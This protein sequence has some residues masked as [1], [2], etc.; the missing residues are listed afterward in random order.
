MAAEYDRSLR[1][2]QSLT[3]AS[4]SQMKQYDAGLKALAIDSGVAPTKLSQGLYFVISAGYSGAA[5]LQALSLAT[6]DAVI[7]L[8]DSKVT[9]NAL[10]TVMQG[11]NEKT[12]DMVKVNGEMLRSV[13]LGK[14]S[15]QDYAGAISKV[16]VLHAQF[17]VTLEDTNATLATLTSSGY[18]SATVA[19]TAYGQLVGIMDGKTD[20]MTKR[21]YKLGLGFDETKFKQMDYQHQLAYLNTV[22]QGHY[23]QLQNVLGGSKQAASAFTTLET[24]SED[25]H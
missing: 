15:M 2:V 5:A 7:G 1:M 13:T 12:S 18:K 19:A 16:A 4:D 9:A 11:F 22:M 21:I 20:L 25:V 23:D 17:H 6:K 24:H 3:G 10:V 8:T 14:M